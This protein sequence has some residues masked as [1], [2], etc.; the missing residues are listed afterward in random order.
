MPDPRAL[1]LPLAEGSFDATLRGGD[2]FVVMERGLCLALRP[3]SWC[4][5]ADT[6]APGL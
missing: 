4:G 3:E 2:D 1:F 6:A 5:A